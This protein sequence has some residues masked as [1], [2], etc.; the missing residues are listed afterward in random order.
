MIKVK[1]IILIFA[2]LSILISSLLA[3]LSFGEDEEGEQE[4]ESGTEEPML[5][6]RN[7]GERADFTLYQREHYN[8][9]VYE[10]DTDGMTVAKSGDTSIYHS[11]GDVRV[12]DGR[13]I[14]EGV[15]NDKLLL[16]ERVRCAQN[17]TESAISFEKHDFVLAVF[18]FKDTKVFYANSIV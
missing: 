4:S 3:L 1:N 18:D 2:I 13:L 10:T 14:F 7:P 6:V 8:G 9:I 17:Y 16:F 15:Q 12:K 5:A 11:F